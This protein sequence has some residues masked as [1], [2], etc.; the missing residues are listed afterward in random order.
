RRWLAEGPAALLAGGWNI[1]AIV[2]LQDGSPVGLTVQTN[3]TNA[4][5]PGALRPNVLRDPALP[6]GDRR[7][8]RWFDTSA[9]TPPPA[10][11]FGNAG[12]ALLT[13]P[14]LANVDLSLLKNFAFTERWNLQ[15]RAEAFNVFNHSNFDDPGRALASPNFGVI[16]AA[17]PARTLQLGLK[18]NF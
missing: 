6:Q 10:Y 1:G 2:T 14:G 13:G 17:R 15:F 9:L 16:T 7:V 5:T 3:T 12:R 11:T 18:L 4:F 8:E